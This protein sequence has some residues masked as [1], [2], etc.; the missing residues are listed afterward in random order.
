MSRSPARSSR[1]GHE[2]RH[3]RLVFVGSTDRWT[4]P[5][6]YSLSISGYARSRTNDLHSDCGSAVA[7]AAFL[8]FPGMVITLD[9]Y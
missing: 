7:G 4:S 5:F 2:A 1:G 6:L 3:R 8:T 9:L